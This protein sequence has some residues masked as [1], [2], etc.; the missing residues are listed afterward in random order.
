MVPF[1]VLLINLINFREKWMKI[2]FRSLL[3]KNIFQ[4]RPQP[5][6]YYFKNITQLQSNPYEPGELKHFTKQEILRLMEKLM[7]YLAKSMNWD[8]VHPIPEARTP[9][10]KLHQAHSNMS[11]DISFSSK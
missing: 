3:Y 5:I 4:P 10:L 7:R 9:I 11:V 6:H 8:Y 1:F 2:L